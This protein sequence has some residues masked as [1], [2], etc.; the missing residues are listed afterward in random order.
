VG[1][2]VGGA[3][4]RALVEAVGGT[5]VG[6]AGGAFVGGREGLLEGCAPSAVSACTHIKYR[7]IFNFPT[8][9]LIFSST[10]SSPTGKWDGCW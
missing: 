10:S 1:G 4:Q 5:G 9:Q 2:A 8:H 6:A 3:V 7:Y